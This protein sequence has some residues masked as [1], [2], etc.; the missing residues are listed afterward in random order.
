M[1]AR[2]VILTGKASSRPTRA[3][4]ES[5]ARRPGRPPPLVQAGLHNSG[6]PLGSAGYAGRAR[7]RAV[8]FCNDNDAVLC[9]S[10][11]AAPPAAAA[12]R[13]VGH[14]GCCLRPLEWPWLCLLA[15]FSAGDP[16]RTRT[17]AGGPARSR[18]PQLLALARGLRNPKK[19]ILRR[20]SP[21]ALQAYGYYPPLMHIGMNNI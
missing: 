1:K 8:F 6:P 18:D 19:H 9:S 20:C 5:W 3:E 11:L 14:A 15:M 21:G 2:E 13:A 7:A 16:D 10:R 4:P 17:A 12:A